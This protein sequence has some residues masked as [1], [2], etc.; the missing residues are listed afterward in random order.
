MIAAAVN[1]HRDS[2]W[3]DLHELGGAEY[4]TFNIHDPESYK[5]YEENKRAAWA[6]QEE[7]KRILQHYRDQYEERMA[8][9]DQDFVRAFNT[10]MLKEDAEGNM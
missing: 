6:A 4:R 9:Q 1:L 8:A 10:M 7:E 5:E 2:E 3:R